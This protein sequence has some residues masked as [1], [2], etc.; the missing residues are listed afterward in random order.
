LICAGLS[1]E[2]TLQIS[3]SYLQD[4]EASYVIFDRRQFVTGEWFDLD[5]L[6]LSGDWEADNSL[7]WKLEPNGE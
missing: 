4:A 3:A 6:L 1:S 7:V 2:A 5:K